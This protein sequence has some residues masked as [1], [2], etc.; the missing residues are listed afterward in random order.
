MWHADGNA[1]LSGPLDPSHL[2]LAYILLVVTYPFPELNEF[3]G[4]CNSSIPRHFL[5][6]A[7][8]S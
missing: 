2:G 6:F 1:Y 3:F 8:F 5:D 7:Y 4:L